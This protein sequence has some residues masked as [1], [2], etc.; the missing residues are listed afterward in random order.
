MADEDLQ[1]LLAALV[2]QARALATRIAGDPDRESPCHFC[3]GPLALWEN[4]LVMQ[5][6]GVAAHVQCPPDTHE[7]K[8]KEVGP[9]PEF[10]YAD[11]SAAVERRLQDTPT[12]A[13]S[14]V[15]LLPAVPPAPD[16]PPAPDT[17]PAPDAP[18]QAVG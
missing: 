1:N 10:P 14:G 13:C 11:F 5:L 4:L 2:E 8:L 9:A 12:T 17:P 16:A 7:Q 6:T 3:G 15:I 18:P